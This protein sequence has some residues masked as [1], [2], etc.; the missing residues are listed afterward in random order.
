MALDDHLTQGVYRIQP[1]DPL[2]GTMKVPGDK[3][4]SHLELLCLV[5][6]R[7][8]TTSISGFLESGDCNHATL[9]AFRQMGVISE[10]KDDRMI[11]QG[12][13]MHGP[14]MP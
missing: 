7:K 3:S 1:S 2:Q 5:R 9:E 14:E 12:A 8:E 6:W 11:I 10:K 13:G 4:I